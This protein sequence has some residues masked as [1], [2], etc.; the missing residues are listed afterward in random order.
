MSSI[1]GVTTW[2]EMLKVGEQ[3]EPTRRLWEAYFERLVRRAHTL[4]GTRC[5]TGGDAED[6]AL[7]AF[8]SFVEAVQNKRFPR[9]DDRTDLWRVLLMLTARK[10]GKHIRR[11]HAP[12]RGGGKVVPFSALQAPGDSAPDTPQVPGDEPD[13]AEAAVLAE[14]FDHLLK[15]LGKED[16][17]QVARWR[18]EGYQNEE[19][20]QRLGRCVGAVE[21]KLK[22]IRDIWERLPQE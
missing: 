14:T 10:A 17:R 19:I 15:V 5:R 18:L 9:L 13:P 1:T 21:R 22:T 11:E 16:L 7:S 4:L 2:L 6:V 12:R 3:D 20:A 8:G